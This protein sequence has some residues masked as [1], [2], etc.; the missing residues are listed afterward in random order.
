MIEI[1]VNKKKAL[2][3]QQK[4]AKLKL[5]FNMSDFFSSFSAFLASDFKTLLCILQV[6]LNIKSKM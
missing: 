1:K 3:L 6:C 4:T 2:K 5:Q